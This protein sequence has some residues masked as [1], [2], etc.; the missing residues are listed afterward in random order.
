MTKDKKFL[1]ILKKEIVIALGCTEP[2]SVALAAAYSA[3]FL[4]AEPETIEV[5]L[6]S[7]VLKN[8]M[9]AGIPGTTLVGI[10][11][12]AVLGMLS[13]KPELELEVLKDL[14]SSDIDYAKKFV[15][16]GKI[17]V[18]E[19]KSKEKLYIEVICKNKSK[20]SRAI[21]KETHANV[22]LIET[23]KE[24]IFDREKQ[25]GIILKNNEGLKKIKLNV[26]EIF[27]FSTKVN[28]EEIKFIID[29]AKLN[30]ALAKEGVEKGYG[31]FVGKTIMDQINV[32]ELGDDIINTAM[33]FTAGASDAR[34]GGV[35]LPAMSN[36]GSGNQGITVMVP[37]YVYA[38]HFEVDDELLARSL[39]LGNL[40]VIHI[41]SHLGRLSAL[42]GAI[43][44]AI[45]ASAGI[46]YLQGASL[47]QINY[48]IKNM[49]ANISGMFCDGA[50]PGC[51]MKV[52]T[53]INAAC[54][55][56]I[57][58]MNNRFVLGPEGIVSEDVE[59]TIINLAKLGSKGLKEADRMILNIMTCK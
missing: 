51:S 20:F 27:D 49:A 44:A 34:M 40:I 29:G 14:K 16:N 22:V 31:L 25:T 42:C 10:H 52:A 15:L 39:V 43:I 59:K 47:D 37:I 32:G 38:K 3:K 4:E 19:K 18:K 5:Y 12:A 48:C 17:T 24:L 36:S 30:M 26:K 50:K 2:T 45:G 56:S 21:I 58:A 35:C 6:S 53:S 55:S 57:L 33:G 28:F 41:K 1:D 13:K 7:N 8:A 11:I 46:S 23:E 9:R 54:M